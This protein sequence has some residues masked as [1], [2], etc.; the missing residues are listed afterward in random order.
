MATIALTPLAVL[1]LSGVAAGTFLALRPVSLR[2]AAIPVVSLLVTLRPLLLPLVAGAIVGL[3]N[4]SW[5]ALFLGAALLGFLAVR[6]LV[7]PEA[8]QLHAAKDWNARQL[9]KHGAWLLLVVVALTLAFKAGASSR[10]LEFD[11]RRRRVRA[12]PHAGPLDDRLPAAARRPLLVMAAARGRGARRAQRPAPRGRGGADARRRPDLRPRRLPRLGAAARRGGPDPA[13]GGARR[14]RRAARRG[15]GAGRAGRSPARPGRGD[16]RRRPAPRRGAAL[17]GPRPHGR[18]PRRGGAARRRGDR[19]ARDQPTRRAAQHPHRDAGRRSRAAPAA[20]QLRRR[21]GAGPRLQPGPRPHPRRA[22]VADLGRP[23]RERSRA[24]RS[25]RAAARRPALGDG[26]A[27]PR[28]PAA[29]LRPLLPALDPLSDGQGGVRRAD[30]AR[31]PRQRRP[32]PRRRRLR[33]HRAARGGGTGRTPA[34]NRTPE[35]LGPP[36]AAGLPP[37]RPLREA[38]DHPAPVLVL[39]P[40][41]RMGNAL[42][43]GSARAAPRRRL[44]G[45]HDRPLGR[46]TA[47]RRLLRPLRGRLG[48]VGRSRTLRRAGA[49]APTRWSPSP[50]GPTPTTRGRRRSARPTGRAARA[51]RGGR[52]PRSATPRTS[53]TRPNTAGSGTR[54]KAAS[55][56][57]P[58]TPCR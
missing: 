41:R 50:R 31:G 2:P 58:K 19:P 29:L 8:A 45:G 55:T 35:A 18:R 30:A 10:A 14:A 34:R 23:L 7:A 56:G 16:P 37:R 17:P 3:A 42:L 32:A 48:P 9:R 5:W 57:P 52:R 15:P 40:L 1:V 44:G 12:R 28:L 4:V 25:A 20:G 46:R 47:L 13:R 49:A 24:Q 22:L 54:P 36:A 53:A 27:R 26:E 43:R 21:H 11:R 6:L 38:T 51:R 33:A 39:L